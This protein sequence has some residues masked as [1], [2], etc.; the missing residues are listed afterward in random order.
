MPYFATTVFDMFMEKAAQMEVPR[1]GQHRAKM[2]DED[3][4]R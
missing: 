3:P 1:C 4:L 2:S